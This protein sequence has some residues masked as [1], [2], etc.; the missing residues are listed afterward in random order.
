MPCS[1]GDNQ[2]KTPG[3]RGEGVGLDHTFILQGFSFRGKMDFQ[4]LTK[5][6]YLKETLCPDRHQDSGANNR[7]LG[8][9]GVQA[10]LLRTSANG[11]SEAAD[12]RSHLT[13]RHGGLRASRTLS[14]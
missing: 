7:T 4:H 10:G 9:S 14:G 1:K 2:I 8:N 3:T 6:N 13:R 12:G 5:C 11:G